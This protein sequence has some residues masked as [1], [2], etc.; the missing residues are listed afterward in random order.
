MF[1]TRLVQGA[2]LLVLFQVSHT[3]E[4]VLTKRAQGNLKNLFDRVPDEAV[5][6]ELD[7]DGTPVISDARNVPA[8]QVVP[9]NNMLVRPGQQVALDGEIVYGEALVSTEHI[10]GESLPVRRKQGSEVPAGALNHDGI[11]VVRASRLAAQSTPARIA[12]LTQ[13]A[14]ASPIPPNCRQALKR[15]LFSSLVTSSSAERRRGNR[16]SVGG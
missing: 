15:S 11:L 1:D 6:V 10:T 8:S 13:Y 7:Q 9:G 3:V 4:H 2:L 16:S 5:L 14:Q 12:R